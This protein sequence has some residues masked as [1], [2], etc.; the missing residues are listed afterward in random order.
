MHFGKTYIPWVLFFVLG[1]Q[2]HKDAHSTHQRRRSLSCLHHR[3]RRM[4]NDTRRR[5][6][7]MRL[8]A[9]IR[10]CF[11]SPPHSP[12]MLITRVIGGVT[13]CPWGLHHS[14]LLM[15][16]NRLERCRL[17]PK[18]AREKALS[19]KSKARISR[20]DVPSKVAE[21]PNPGCLPCDRGAL[22]LAPIQS[23]L[24]HCEVR[25]RVPPALDRRRRKKLPVAS[26][27]RDGS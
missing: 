17:A 12:A 2:E 1:Q 5:C 7:Q 10:S 16:L 14:N 27:A 25:W 9:C 8:N 13:V 23:S 19:A 11:I 24:R 26:C 15:I 3:H 22:P 18:E 21:K 4:G 6:D 20:S